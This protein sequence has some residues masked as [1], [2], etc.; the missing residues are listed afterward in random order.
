MLLKKIDR[1]RLFL[2]KNHELFACPNCHEWLTMQANSFVCPNKHQ[3]DLNKK[4]NLHFL[5]HHVKTDYDKEM[6]VPRQKMIQSGL[7][8][9]LIDWILA[10]L[11]QDQVTSVVDMGCGEGSFLQ[12][13]DQQ[14]LPGT[15]IGFD[16]SKDGVALATNQN[17]EA[18]WCVAD[19]TNLPFG[20]QTISHLLNIFSP[21]HYK[22]FQRVLAPGGKLIKVV[23]EA[24]YLKELRDLFYDDQVEKQSYS[25]QKVVT[26][27]KE[28]MV[29]LK[30]ERVTYHIPVTDENYANIL[31]MS[32]LKWGANPEILDEVLSKRQID[33]LTIDILILVGE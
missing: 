4:G 20:N 8:Q 30:T 17:L 12:Q 23:P 18:F 16:I 27:F 2:E 24:G 7:Y 9:P 6:L 21:S 33:S 22:E 11:Q 31:A 32:P 13:L 14:G 5:N 19:I 25:N 29:C 15:K 28:E 3:F 26:K 1:S 10:Y